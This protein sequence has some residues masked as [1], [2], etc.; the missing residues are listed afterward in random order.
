MVRGVL[1]APEGHQSAILGAIAPCQKITPP[2]PDKAWLPLSDKDATASEPRI[3]TN[4]DVF[5]T[6]PAPPPPILLAAELFVNIV[7]VHAA[8]LRL[9]T[10]MP[11]PDPAELQFPNLDPVNVILV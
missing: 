2:P 9:L 10:D 7:S 6:K 8:L 11:P 4:K 1:N 3:I 5:E